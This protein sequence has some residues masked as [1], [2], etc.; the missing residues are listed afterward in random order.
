M[1]RRT[2]SRPTGAR[3]RW[4]QRFWTTCDAA[5][6][7]G[8]GPQRAGQAQAPQGCPESPGQPRWPLRK[9][10]V[11]A[12]G[13]AGPGPAWDLAF[14]ATLGFRVLGGVPKGC[15]LIPTAVSQLGVR[16]AGRATTPPSG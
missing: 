15:A 16:Q 13:A 10:R 7:P 11:P 9:D 1:R 4:R 8:L 3:T 2:S 12:P 5:L 14:G 6:G